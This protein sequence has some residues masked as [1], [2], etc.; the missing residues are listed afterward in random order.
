MIEPEIK[1]HTGE[2]EEGKHYD[3]GDGFTY[4]K[5]DFCVTEPHRAGDGMFHPKYAL[6]PAH[7]GLPF[8][9]IDKKKAQYRGDAQFTKD[10]KPWRNLC[11][12]LREEEHSCLEFKESLSRRENG[13]L[14]FDNI[15]K[16]VIGFTN[17][18]GGE[19]LLGVSDDGKIT[20]IN[21][22]ID[23]YE[24]RDKFEL[25]LR[26]ALHS[27]IDVPVDRIY[28]IKF[29]EIDKKVI[30][31]VKVKKSKCQVFTKQKGEYYI[32]DGNQTR[33][34]TPKEVSNRRDYDDK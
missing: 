6:V 26:D 1:N 7:E 3:I 5:F 31:R 12:L 28:C 16:S 19:I 18:D 9:K 4:K 17:T 27:D 21:D 22:L 32:R 8:K 10:K 30:L 2:W 29:E 34:L 20:G 11:E 23:Q 14:I 24:N 33:A 15:I 13:K 25:A